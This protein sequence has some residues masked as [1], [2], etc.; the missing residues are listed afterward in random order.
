MSQGPDVLR[1][2]LTLSC[3]DCS[4]NYDRIRANGED[5]FLCVYDNKI[6]HVRVSNLVSVIFIP[7]RRESKMDTIDFTF[8]AFTI[9]IKVRLEVHFPS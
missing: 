5:L 8:L 7:Y 6:Q 2:D 4:I 1:T 9:L 3:Y